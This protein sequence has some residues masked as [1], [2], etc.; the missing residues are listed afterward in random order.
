MCN[1]TKKGF[2]GKFFHINFAKFSED[3]LQETD[4]VGTKIPTDPA[5]IIIC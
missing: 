5:D 2:R 4:Y 3:L 1:L